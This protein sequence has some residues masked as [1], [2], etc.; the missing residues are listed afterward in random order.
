MGRL[1]ETTVGGRNDIARTHIEGEGR[2]LDVW[3]QGRL[4]LPEP[5]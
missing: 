4:L 5:K 1:I 3:S 2:E